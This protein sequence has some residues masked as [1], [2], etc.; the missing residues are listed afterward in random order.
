MEARLNAQQESPAAYAAMVGLKTSIRKASK[1][2]PSLV[3]LGCGLKVCFNGVK[4]LRVADGS[5][6]PRVATGN[7]HAPCVIIRRAHGG[8]AL[9]G[10][11]NS[12]F[13][14][15]AISKYYP[16]QKERGTKQ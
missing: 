15:S 7:T 11:V 3:V 14:F 8:N 5:I 10:S 6:M 4:N 9:G 12:H 1:L 2:E 13:C 16:F